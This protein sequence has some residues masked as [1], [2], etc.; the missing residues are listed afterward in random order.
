MK[1]SH[2][3]LSMKTTR[4]GALTTKI[5][6][7]HT[8]K[9]NHH[10]SLT[11][12]AYRRSDADGRLGDEDLNVAV[13]ILKEASADKDIQKGSLTPPPIPE[14]TLTYRPEVVD[15][16]VRNFLVKNNMWRTLDCFQH[17]WYELKHK[18]KLSSSDMGTVPDVYVKNSQLDHENQYLKQEL[19]RFK[20]AA[21]GAKDH[22]IKMRK[23]RDFHRMH[24]RRVVQEKNS[25]IDNLA[26]LR[27]HYDSYEPALQH[28]KKKYE[29]AM[30]EKMLSKLERDRALGQVSGLQATLKSVNNIRSE[31][32]TNFT[33]AEGGKITG[34]LSRSP[35]APSRVDSTLGGTQQRLYEARRSDLANAKPNTLDPMDVTNI[36]LPRHTEDTVWPKDKGVNPDLSKVIPPC[37][38][39]TRVGGF[40]LTHTF[41]AHDLA[42]SSMALHPKEDMLVTTSDD[43]KWKMWQVNKI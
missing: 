23:E 42:V 35:E 10:S 19:E 2:G 24:H 9:K 16:F 38:H 37:A 26:K 36:K 43:R 32:Q 14:A 4:G 20:A 33:F 15:D 31:S 21:S 18:G 5:H 41:Q 29:V 6:F 28:L 34:K 13:Q 3:N 12:R 1:F 8:N 22:F 11:D 30:R 27:K 17:E 25:L 40:R 7:I 39:L